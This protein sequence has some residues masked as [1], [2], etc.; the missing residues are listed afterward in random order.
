LVFFFAALIGAISLLSRKVDGQPRWPE[1]LLLLVSWLGMGYFLL[2]YQVSDLEVFFIPL[3]VIVAI[4]VNEGLASLAEA[5]EAFLRAFHVRKRTSRVF[6]S[7]VVLGI[8]ACAL[9]GSKD[10]V[11]KSIQQGRISFLDESRMYY[12]Y[13]VMDPGYPYREA[14][15]IAG[16]VE[17]NAILFVDWDLLFPVCYVAHVEE[18]RHGIACYEPLPFGTN[19]QFAASAIEFVNEYKDQRP[20]YF[21]TIP[22]NIRGLYQFKQVGW[23]RPLYKLE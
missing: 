7:L 3:F 22:E 4:W 23:T 2:N 21:S 12:P 9:L 5:I 13:P 6:G 19:G 14:K 11:L 8:C 10:P 15:K 16:M 18:Q 20:I 17:D 1:G